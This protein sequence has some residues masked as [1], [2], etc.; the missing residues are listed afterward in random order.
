[1]SGTC[2]FRKPTT[3]F[4]S[5]NQSLHNLAVDV[6]IHDRKKGENCPEGIPESVISEYI[7]GKNFPVVGT[8]MNNLILVIY[9]EE[10][11]GK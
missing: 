1:M 5:I 10:L 8:I 4:V 3:L 6:R 7:T 11:P 9:L 2:P